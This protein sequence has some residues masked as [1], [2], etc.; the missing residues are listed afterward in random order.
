MKLVKQRQKKKIKI[1]VLLLIVLIVSKLLLQRRKRKK[2]N[3][4]NQSEF[5][6][7][8]NQFGEFNC[9]DLNFYY[10][11]KKERKL[12]KSLLH[13]IAHWQGPCQKL[14]KNVSENKDQ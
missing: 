8:L 5:V 14:S 13:Y 4:E 2:E 7:K 10:D 1:V 12:V 6:Q 11:E 3:S 9:V